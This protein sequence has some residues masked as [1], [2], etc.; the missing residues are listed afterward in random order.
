MQVEFEGLIKLLS[1]KSLTSLDKEADLKI[2][3]NAEDDELI[4]G[5]NKLHKADQTVRIT[6][7]SGEE[8]Q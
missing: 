6:I 5:I 7:E 1:I 2:R 4:N 8:R 3:F